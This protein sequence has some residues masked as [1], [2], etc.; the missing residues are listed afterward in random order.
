MTSA[1]CPHLGLSSL[2]SSVQSLEG[3]EKVDN[4]NLGLTKTASCIL[5]VEH[6]NMILLPSS[7]VEPTDLP[8]FAYFAYPA[9]TN[10]LL[11]F[12]MYRLPNRCHYDL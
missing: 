2:T 7:N 9:Y 8:R 6:N 5:Q 4:S 1:A 10:R 11:H 3:S 12:L